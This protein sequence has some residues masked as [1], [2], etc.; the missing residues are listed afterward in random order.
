M[1]D[2]LNNANTYWVLIGCMLLG[3]SGGFLGSFALLRRRSL[4]GDALAHAA[5]PG[6]CL[7][8]LLFGSRS[9][10]VLLSGAIVASIAGALLIQY[11]T[12]YSKLKEDAALGM[13]LSVFFAFGIVLLTVIQ[14]SG[15]GN[16]SGLDK[17]LFGQAASL[18][19]PD[20]T[21]MAV[22]SA[23]IGF[24]CILFFKEFKLLCFDIEFAKGLGYP[25]FA[26][27]TLLNF[28]L[29]L[30]VV[31]GLQAVGVVLMAAMLITPAAAARFWTER[32]DRMVILA[33][34]IGALSGA[35]G[36][37]LS[38]MAFRMPT[39]PLIVLAATMMFLISLV[40]APQKGLL[41]KFLRFLIL[42]RKVAREN[43][44]RSLYEIA[45]SHD[46]WN[47]EI[48]PKT[49]AEH[50]Y[51]SES[52]IVKQLAGLKKDEL[53]TQTGLGYCLTE[54]GIQEAYQLVRN[55]RLWEMF[56][57][58]EQQLGSDHVHRDADMIEHFLSSEIVEELDRLLRL[59]DRDLKL[60]PSVHPIAN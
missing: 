11:I 9:I 36:T 48:L 40:F 15:D 32:L 34:I 35:F 57:M 14:H 26:L 5:L 7:A 6:I 42:Q 24:F 45:E 33:G 43:T 46:S 54:K 21:I 13:V 60:L 51:I 56:L 27:D 17:Y 19:G 47:V 30:T 10:T 16:Q 4:M 53:V 59:H 44:L 37:L 23:I 8:F 12:R 18:I 1:F 50:R 55:H 58:H 25:V 38:A 29:V 41:A 49:V 31:I 39:G 3:G 22:T 20:I 2:W 52:H 28:L